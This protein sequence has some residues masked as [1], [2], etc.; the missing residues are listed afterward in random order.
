MYEELKKRK[1]E[2][3]PV[4]DPAWDEVEKKVSGT[5]ATKAIN[6]LKS[7]NVNAENIRAVLTME[8]GHRPEDQNVYLPD[9]Y[10]EEHKNL[11]NKG[12]AFI[13]NGNAYLTFSYQKAQIGDPEGL[14]ITTPEVLNKVQDAAR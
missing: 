10:V 2:A 12:A 8:K 4:S 11:F 3:T 6:K 1:N 9:G 14:F 7:K 13:Q 5:N